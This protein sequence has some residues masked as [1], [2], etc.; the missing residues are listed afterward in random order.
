MP[1]PVPLVDRPRSPTQRAWA[2]F[3][4]NRLGTVSLAIFVA[5]LVLSAMAELLSNDKPLLAS[6]HGQLYFP[7]FHNPPEVSFGGDFRTPTDWRD[8]FIDEQFAKPDNW[9]LHTLNRHSA[10]STDYFSKPPNPTPPSAT[11]ILGTDPIGRDM[12]ARL[13]Y[14]FRV[15][16]LFAIALTTIGVLLGLAAGAVQG[17]FA[18]RVD[19][20]M[21]RLIEIW[22]SVPELYLLIIFASIF[23]PSVL[24]LLVLL[25]LFG[26]V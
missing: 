9:R 22:T 13:L 12:V 6:Y 19:L 25:S 1:A 23:Q 11:N 26:W 4:R 5:M 10:T 24:L 17:Y 2:R 15:S 20:T 18:G 16:I 8:P 21:Q 3:R 14:G 7:L